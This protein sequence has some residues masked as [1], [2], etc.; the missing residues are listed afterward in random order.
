M[1]HIG[2]LALF[3]LLTPAASFAADGLPSGWTFHG[4][5]N[6]Q[7]QAHAE[8][9]VGGGIP[10][11][12]LSDARGVSGTLVIADER[13]RCTSGDL[14]VLTLEAKGKGRMNAGVHC[15]DEKGAWN[16]PT[17]GVSGGS[18]ELGSAWKEHRFHLAP[19]DG[20]RPLA[21]IRTVVGCTKGSEIEFRNVRVRTVARQPLPRIVPTETFD[22]AKAG[23]KL[24]F[25]DEFDAPAGAPFDPEKWEVAVWRKHGECVEHD[26]KGNLKVKCELDPETG[27]LYS[28][29]L[30]TKPGWVYGCY[31]A[32]LRFTHREGW[33]SSFWMY[34]WNN[35]NPFEDGSE[36][37]IY[38][39]AGTRR[40]GG[41][42]PVALDHTLHMYNQ[43]R[44]KSASFKSKA[45]GGVDRF[46]TI[47]C[48]WT[49][50]EISVYVDGRRTATFDAFR[51]GAVKAPLH[52]LLTGCIMKKGVKDVEA[53]KQMF[54]ESMIVDYVRIY[55]YPGDGAPQVRWHGGG[56]QF[57]RKEGETMPFDFRVK[58]DRPIRAAY[59][60]DSGYCVATCTE[61]PWRF[62]L[63]FSRAHYETTAYAVPGVQCAAPDWV[64]TLHS[65]NIFV[66][67]ADGRIGVTEFPRR[68]MVED[69]VRN[70]P[71]P[72]DVQRIPG[73]VK[74]S[75]AANGE[76]K[77]L[78]TGEPVAV[79]AEVESDGRYS[80]SLRYGAIHDDAH[81]LQVVVD[82]KLLGEFRCVPDP[83]GD[84][85][86]RQDTAKIEFNLTGG[87]HRILFVPIGSI[88]GGPVSVTRIN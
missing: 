65:F 48:K 27:K 60:F 26:G 9:T 62:E 79:E 6:Y 19:G 3:V 55:A 61:A 24:V 33:W 86:A 15:F 53:A 70:L 39:D 69:G 40:P 10:A 25:A 46:H 31:E 58:A 32:R 8:T 66:E 13:T 5:D 45:E 85:A 64:N 35:R 73:S 43:G 71:G 74:L 87:R 75:D 37:D 84:S 16:P 29:S 59:L 14:V 88:V 77:G 56:R 20:R 28:T 34:G 47:A 81:R 30:W 67:D 7:P 78:R 23:W 63:P 76:A 18:A 68:H 2:Y 1:K 49:P 52:A 22:A 83:A 44:L 38:E 51:N 57:V 41:D 36:I 72:K 17:N 54:P 80:A 4:Y 50:F 21:Q 82:G 11:I 42:D 12:R